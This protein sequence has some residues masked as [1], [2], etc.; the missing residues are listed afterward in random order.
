[1]RLASVSLDSTV[2]LWD[3]STGK[4]VLTVE[5][6]AN[7]QAVAFSPDGRRLVATGRLSAGIGQDVSTLLTVTGPSAGR[8]GAEG[9]TVWDATP[10]TD[11]P[12]PEE[13]RLV[14]LG[15]RLLEPISFAGFYVDRKLTLQ[16]AL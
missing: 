5:A 9:P 8:G 13:R 14:Q 2:K 16:E 12:T 6:F 4:N 7:P 15:E 1:R 10:L 11:A 3:P